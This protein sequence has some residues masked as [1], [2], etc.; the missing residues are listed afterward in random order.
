M[1]VTVDREYAMNIS[2]YSFG[3]IVIEG[4]NYTKD[5]I[6]FPDRVFSPWWRK[7]GHLLHTE[8]LTEVYSAKPSVLIVGTG[9]NDTM[10]VPEEVIDALRSKGI[11][12]QVRDTTAAV[13]L[14]NKLTLEKH[15][16]AAL[17]LTC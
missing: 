5:V 12:V 11:E 17:H 4:K 13:E 8:D 3:R 6:V 9:Y 7:E 16:A 15:V 14:F 10:R 2:H 1:A